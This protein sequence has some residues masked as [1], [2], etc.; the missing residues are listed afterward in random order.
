MRENPRVQAPAYLLAID[1]A[2]MAERIK[3]FGG[4]ADT[5]AGAAERSLYPFF[6]S[7]REEQGIVNR[8]RAG[9]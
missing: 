2:E 6:F 3:E 1:L 4:T 8:L 7:D 9:S 5:P